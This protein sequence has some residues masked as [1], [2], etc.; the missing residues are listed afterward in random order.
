MTLGVNTEV[1]FRVYAVNYN[2]LRENMRKKVNI[3]NI[4]LLVKIKFFATNS[5]CGD[6]LKVKD[7][8]NFW[9]HKFGQDKT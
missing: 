4:Y 2:V 7:T 5:N 9:K 8:K 3:L 1:N 6:I